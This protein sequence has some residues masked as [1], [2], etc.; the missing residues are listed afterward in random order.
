MSNSGESF[1]ILCNQENFLLGGNGYKIKQCLRNAHVILKSAVKNSHNNGRPRNGMFIAVPAEIKEHVTDVSPSHWRVQAV[2]VS[3]D[4]SKVLIIN[5]YFPTDPKVQDFDSSE[6]L[7]T[8]LSIEDVMKRNDYD[9]AVW[10][11]DINADFSRRT[12]FTGIIKTFIDQN[13][14]KKSWDKFPIDFTHVHEVDSTTY[15]STIDHFMWTE[16]LEQH[17]VDAGVLHLPNNLSDHCP[18][19]CHLNIGGLKTKSVP[20]NS[21]DPTPSWKKASNEQ[22]INYITTLEDNLQK[23]KYDECIIKCHDVH[24]Q[25]ECHRQASDD[26]VVNILET[27]ARTGST[28]LQN[29]VKH[30]KKQKKASIASWAEEVQ[31]FKEE[32]FFWHSIW[33]SCGRPIN[34]EV[35]KIMKRTRNVY[36]YQIRKCKKMVDTLKKNAL[37]DA[38]INEK[39]DIFTEIR[40]MRR[41]SPSV[42]KI[43][44]GVADNIPDHFAGIYSKLYNSVNDDE[45]LMNTFNL[46]N[47]KITSLSMEQVMKITPEVVGKAISKLKSNKKDPTFFLTSDYLTNAPPV[48]YDHLSNLLRFYLIHGHI[49]N[50]LTLSTL[51]PLIKDKLG[52]IYSSDNYRSIAL[53][54]L[55][56]KILDWVIILLYGDKLQLD[57]LQFAYQA[58]C[59]TNMCS[60]L[61]VETI[62]HFVRNGSNVYTCVMDMK[63]AFDTVKHSTLFHKLLKRGIPE[64]YV[65]LLFITYNSQCANVTWNGVKSTSFPIRNGVKQGAV[66][67]AILYCTYIDD[68]FKM[69]RKKKS[70][71]WINGEFYGIL[72]YADDILLL[73]PTLDGLQDMVNTCS[74]YANTHNL[75]FS[76]N[77]N[78]AKCK[79]KCMAILNTERELR[80][81]KL[82]GNDLPWV[83]SAKHLGTLIENIEHGITRDIMEKR[84]TYINRN[85]ELLQELYFAHP[86][87]IIKVNNIYNTSFYGSMIWNLFGNEATRLEKTWNVSQRLMLKLD[88]KTHRFFI[89]PLSETP[90][91]I[92]SLYKRF[93]SFTQK[94]SLSKKAPLRHLFNIVKNDCRSTTGGNLRRIMLR[95]HVDTPGNLNADV[96]T[97]SMYHETPAGEEWKLAVAKELIDAINGRNIIPQFKE[98]ELQ[99]IL[100]YITTYSLPICVFPAVIQSDCLNC[101][102]FITVFPGGLKSLQC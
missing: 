86:Q 84:A 93:I 98:K 89:E 75:S 101:G 77:T 87:T 62:D 100:D 71:C 91:I 99:S 14:L 10:A 12:R 47:K 79:T 72:G 67:S 66:L 36:H 26:L 60:W 70:G 65:R 15:T 40:K 32:A 57:D 24:C 21:S 97:K 2:I 6:L 95:F 68:L 44:D 20:L 58:N 46:V 96:V 94:L 17:I 25:K 3:S 55:L 48:L 27:I 9:S 63:K 78:T 19:F 38:C 8:L 54:S 102:R 4:D 53:S 82:N 64:I 11:G 52:D 7:T 51:I 50:I 16:N 76:T 29:N 39:S 83:S 31:P 85:N 61:V 33:K 42:A 22:K 90:H 69:L 23:L 18:I 41:C 30:F 34:T 73:S 49:S 13:Q 88:R 81:I 80:N 35:H 37:L 5:T 43:I 56:L 74:T 59:S 45:P 1:S 92:F 28:C